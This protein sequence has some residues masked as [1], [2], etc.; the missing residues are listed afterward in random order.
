MTYER[1]NLAEQLKHT[2]DLLEQDACQPGQQLYLVALAISPGNTVTLISS[3]PPKLTRADLLAAANVLQ[4]EVYSITDTINQ[5]II[6][7]RE[8]RGESE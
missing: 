1:P 2:R 7:G 8:T 3:P 6:R 5:N 4:R